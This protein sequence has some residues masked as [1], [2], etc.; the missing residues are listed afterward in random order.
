[1]VYHHTAKNRSALCHLITDFN[2]VNQRRLARFDLWGVLVSGLLAAVL[3]ESVR[4]L[5]SH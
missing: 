3:V 2:S 5:V 4:L 1:M